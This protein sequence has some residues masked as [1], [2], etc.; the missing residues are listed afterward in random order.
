MIAR[1]RVAALF[2]L[3][4]ASGLVFE[5]IWVRQLAVWAGHGTVAVSLVVAA[6]LAGMVLGNLLGGHLAD[7]GGRLVRV[8]A[9]LE[10]VTGLAAFAV[11]ALLSQAAH[12]SLFLADHAP[13]LFSTLTAR[14]V[15]GFVVLLVPTVAMGAT[16]PVLARHLSRERDVHAPLGTLY[17]LNTL[18]AT[19][20]CALA[21]FVLL[22]TF[23]MLRT[24][25]LA[26]GT[27]FLVALLAGSLDADGTPPAASPPVP[28][29][30]P[31]RRALLAMAVAT[32]FAAIACEVSWFRVLR[33]FVRSSTY[34]FTL[35]LVTYL[36]GL[37]LGGWL[38]ARRMA[39]HPRP[40]SLLADV[41][42]TLAAA[43]LVSVAILGRTGSLTAWLTR[44]TGHHADTDADLIHFGVGVAVILVP[45]TLMGLSFPL[46]TSMGAQRNMRGPGH[47]MGTLAAANT[48]G[49]ALGSLVTGLVLIPWLGTQRSFASMVLVSLAVSLAA[50]RFADGALT[51]RGDAGRSARVALAVSLA[52]AMV[53][54]D[55]LLRAS[56]T[57][58]RGRVLEIREGRDGTAAVLGYDRSTVCRASRNG[59]RNRCLDDFSYRQL[60]FG[61]VSYA[62]TIPFA[63]R[64]MR[65]LAHL[66]MLLH[67]DD[68][69]LDVIEVCFGTGTTAG[70]FTAHPS[71]GTLTI[72][73]INRDVFAFAR[74]FEDS[75]HRVL[76][77]ARVTAV[78][79]DGRH[80][81]AIA[82]RRWDVVSLEPP[83]PTA[84]G[85]A[86]LYTREFYAAA[87][88]RMRPGAI[89]AQWIPF[90][91][92]N[93][94][95]D[96][97]MLAALLAE[98]AYVE[99]YLPSRVE[100]VVLAS[101]RPITPDL[102]HWHSR[103]RAPAVRESLAEVGFAS[104]ES[105][106]AT[107]VLDAMGTRLW[108]G[109]SSPMVDDLPA[110]EFYRSWPGAAFDARTMLALR[111]REAPPGT[112]DPGLYA[113]QSRVEAMGLA[114]W[115]RALA[116]DMVGA[117]EIARAMRQLDTASPYTRYL[118][119]LE[120]D[121]LG[122]DDP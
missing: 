103:W 88:R 74:Y 15:L 56:S 117:R 80:H 50:R 1:R 93:V 83:P 42:S 10:A 5:V 65:A 97:A 25:L 52:L 13:A 6:F 100:G 26:S 62:S 22:G 57:F 37:V 113:R 38:Y 106:A 49:G 34:A 82:R 69:P 47:G 68:R 115:H 58:P 61:T 70:A 9:L 17:A 29:P 18:G 28:H 75:N 110:V 4:G 72:V 89:L 63:K 44:W 95:L 7:R 120:Y 46:L 40:W 51:L 30:L 105:L 96:R 91:Q 39:A 119:V 114:A 31:E 36:L 85:A 35:L 99:V 54:G 92:Q 14:I 8:Y 3:S 43:T 112:L 111:P 109:T 60:L 24:A 76:D 107:R 23:G 19:L 33:A 77:D 59:C 2:V 98:F 116:G 121:C 41:Q 48:L 81:L 73:D 64:Y 87:R 16:L 78:V 122:Y 108:V 27:N 86:S 71:L 90:D 20:G 11:S 66:P 104:P 32:G 55:Y 118:E 21:G 94:V 101:D 84:E 79:D 102:N 12:L 45:A 53:P 67:G